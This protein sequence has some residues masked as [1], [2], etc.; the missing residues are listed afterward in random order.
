MSLQRYIVGIVDA[1]FIFLFFATID[2]NVT[3]SMVE[4]IC[5]KD[6]LM[7]CVCM[8]LYATPIYGYMC[9]DAICLSERVWCCCLV[10]LS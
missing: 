3:F 10:Q 1:V 8:A 6:P 9:L 4:S 2:V 7:P 5:C